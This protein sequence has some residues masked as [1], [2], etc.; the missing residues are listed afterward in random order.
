MKVKAVIMAG[1]VGE[2]FWPKSRIKNPK[3]LLPITGDRP[4]IKNTVNRLKTFMPVKDIMIIT[5][6]LY[7][8]AIRRLVPEL[9]AAN[10]IGEP[11]GRNTA[12]CIGLAAV[13]IK[14][15]D[16]VMIM[17]PSDHV[18]SPVKRFA[19]TLG[20]AAVLAEK[21]D[22]LITMGLK[23]SCGSTAYGYIK[24]GKKFVLKDG[25]KG[26]GKPRGI[27]AYRVEAFVEKPDE[28]T[29]GKYV[30]N[31]SYLWNSGIFIWRK[32][33]ILSAMKKHLPDVHRKLLKIKGSNIKSIYPA[34]ERVSIDYG[35]MEKVDNRLIIA[36]DFNWND[37]GSWEALDKCF[38]KDRRGN[39]KQGN[40]LAFD[41]SDNMI[42]A[43]KD[44]VVTLGV[45]GLII[46]S[47]DD[48]I[49]ILKNGRGEEVKKVVGRLKVD[50]KLKKYL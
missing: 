36:A 37:V 9:P 5:G 41:S 38:P 1:G 48:A 3:Q 14:E 29:A 19:E 21:T 20:W 7:V 18:I 28:K 44:L 8:K 27:E 22:N 47:T 50:K 46:V 23:P 35:I 2:R 34:I 43:E 12:P 26:R 30:K 40:V 25:G 24:E 6:E 10:V 17:F 45:S 49:I 16:A 15:K 33:V 39:I 32:S 4:M 42:F 31:G 13:K 11:L